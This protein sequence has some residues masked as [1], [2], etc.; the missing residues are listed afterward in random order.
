MF[1]ISR[2]LHRRYALHSVSDDIYLKFVNGYSIS[3]KFGVK[4]VWTFICGSGVYRLCIEAI[5]G[6]VRKYGRRKL[7]S[8]VMAGLVWLGCP[9]MPLITNS[10]KLIKIANATHT[11]IAF[12]AE[13]F[14]DCTNAM[15][16]PLDLI[17]VGQSIPI[18][19][20]G[21]YNLMCGDESLFRFF[22]D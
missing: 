3:K 15:W 14:E 13:T 12:I 22:N 19:E 16:L 9:I 21:R 5:K 20:A 4:S 6:E 10:S 7:A 2:P 11:S 8:G 1:T 18:G 17:L